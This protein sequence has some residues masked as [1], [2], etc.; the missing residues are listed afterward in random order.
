MQVVPMGW[1]EIKKFLGKQVVAERRIELDRGKARERRAK[2]HDGRQCHGPGMLA[3]QA[4]KCADA[5]GGG[6]A[7]AQANLAVEKIMARDRDAVELIDGFTRG[8]EG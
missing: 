3:H 4:R 1:I 8:A 5:V 2:E 7:P 6:G